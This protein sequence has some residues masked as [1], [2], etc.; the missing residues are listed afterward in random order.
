V[1]QVFIIALALRAVWVLIANQMPSLS[2]RFVPEDVG[3]TYRPMALAA[4]GSF[5][6]YLGTDRGLF[7][8]PLFPIWLAFC[9]VVLGVDAPSW[10]LGLMNAMLR[11]GSVAF[12]FVIAQRLCGRRAAL[13]AATLMILDP[14]ES[15]WTPFVLKETL[16]VFL[17]LLAVMALQRALKPGANLKAPI[18]ASLLMLLGGLASYGTLILLFLSPRLRFAQGRPGALLW[19]FRWIAGPLLLFVGVAESQQ[20][21]LPRSVRALSWLVEG[22]ITSLVSPTE[23]SGYS[24]GDDTRFVDPQVNLLQESAGSPRVWSAMG[25][26][27]VRRIV[28]LSRPVMS[29]SKVTTFIVLGVPYLAL[30]A[31]SIGGFARSPKRLFFCSGGA[32]VI[33]LVLLLNNSGVRQRQYVMPWLYPAAGLSVTRLI[34]R[35]TMPDFSNDLKKEKFRVS[36]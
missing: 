15:F 29:G 32:A 34:R 22:P 23:T 36:T 25:R 31:L 10:A 24:P 7:V 4:L 1:L 33:T 8:P 17:M 11:A 30:L 19:T 12:V 16:A 3:E 35:R 21:M 28:N 6:P 14:W 27:F 9:Y 26:G 2:I 13:G 18:I 5:D 20:F